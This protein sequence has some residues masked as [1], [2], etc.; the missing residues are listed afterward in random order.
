MNVSY[1]DPAALLQRLIRFDTTNPPGNER[2]CIQF[3]AGLL[4]EAGIPYSI[5]A[6]DPA[7]PNLLARVA[8]RGD[9]PPL[10]LYGHV[11]VVTTTDQA[12]DQPPFSGN[13][14]DG[15]I[16]GRGA[17]DMKG[18]VAM[19][20]SAF[21]RTH[22][23]GP[24]PSGDLLLA[25]LSDEENGGKF[26]ARYLVE[27]HAHLFAGVRHAVG[28]FGGFSM[29]VGGQRFY[30]IAVSERH[31]CWLKA[32]FHGPGGHGSRPISGGAMMKMA[33][34]IQVLDA[35]R[36]PTHIT[37]V[38]RLMVESISRALPEPLSSGLLLLLDPT[39]TDSVL[40]GLGPHA[41]LFASLFHNTVSPTIVYGG[42]KLNVIPSRVTVEMDGR[43]LPGFGP[44]D[45]LAELAAQ[46]DSGISDG[47]GLGDGVQVEVVSYE[48]GPQKPDMTLFDALAGVLRE[49][50]PSGIP[51][52]FMLS[53]VT[54]GRFFARLGIQTYG[55]LPMNLPADFAF[56]GMIHAAN[57]RIPAEAVRFGAEC[58][59]RF[60]GRYYAIGS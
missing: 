36:F 16:W 34:F 31:I 58:I 29:Q 35:Q 26:G 42:E 30:P 2:A 21:L 20:L 44:D 40:A 55:Y 51:I 57:E 3:I 18:G 1:H 27:E 33:R 12:W 43:L 10:L 25:I 7:R 8:G 13:L 45:M 60:L 54:D 47:A 41:G 9:A 24:Q 50:D 19:L 49:A 15:E 52:P 22:V 32:T 53:G 14:V 48:A 5:V 17:L 4:E 37:P 46:L 38:A 56:A 39:Q 11:D 28:E 23:E 59:Y 6:R